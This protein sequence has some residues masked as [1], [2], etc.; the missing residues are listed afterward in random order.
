MHSSF[1]LAV[2]GGLAGLFAAALGTAQQSEQTPELKWH[3]SSDWLRGL[4]RR[5]AFASSLPG[6]ETSRNE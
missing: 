1:R 2:A 4:L 5:I 6:P 3:P